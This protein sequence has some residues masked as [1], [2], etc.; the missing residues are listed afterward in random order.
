M[1]EL[2][3]RL[4]EG[5]V[6][7]QRFSPKRHRLKYRMFQILFDLD[8]LPKLDRRLGL[9]SHNRF[10]LFGFDDRDHGTGVAGS[11]RPY[12]EGL[13]GSIG[14]SAQGG[15]IQLLCMPR[16]LGFVFNPLSIYYCHDRSG[17]LVALIY[18]VNNTFGQRHS[19]L[20][21]AGPTDQG[22]YKQSC[23]KVFHVSP[24]MG[25]D[26]VY[27][28]RI[29]APGET[30]VTAIRGHD[31][32]G[33]EVIFAAFTGRARALSDRRLLATFLSFPF[34]T[35][36]AVAAIHWEAVL[37]LLKGV[38]LQPTP[39]PPPGPVSATPRI[40]PVHETDMQSA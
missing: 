22:V 1:S 30:I 8:E 4:F 5:E 7:H 10:N 39:A 14:L 24:F 36:G 23:A 6:V 35:L 12:V 27:A 31:P 26:L 19:Y 18:E 11:L 13:L 2:A 9:F 3:S 25:M 34:L 32:A 29:G 21:A 17:E 40:T 37:L 15:R 38:R 16:V 20:I 28:F 33:A